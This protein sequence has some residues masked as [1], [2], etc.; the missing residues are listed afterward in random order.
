[1]AVAN[2]SLPM[3]AIMRNPT[4][5]LPVAQ[6]AGVGGLALT[7]LSNLLTCL[8]LLYGV[9]AVRA[10]ACMEVGLVTAAFKV[11]WV[12]ACFASAAVGVLITHIVS[13][14]LGKRITA[15]W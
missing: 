7:T 13:D 11:S 3:P 9:W 15:A 10:W 1:M 12:M 2:Q 5:P 8:R 4:Y 14:G 6:A